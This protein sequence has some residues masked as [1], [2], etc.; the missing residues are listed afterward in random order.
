MFSAPRFCRPKPSSGA[1]S[2]PPL[3]SYSRPM[4]SSRP[5]PVDQP[6][7]PPGGEGL[8]N[9]LRR[10]PGRARTCRPR[11]ARPRQSGDRILDDDPAE[12]RGQRREL[13]G[14][15]IGDLIGFQLARRGQPRDD[16]SGLRPSAVHALTIHAQSGFHA[17][18]DYASRLAVGISP[19]SRLDNRVMPLGRGVA[20]QLIFCA[21]ELTVAKDA[22][23]APTS[24]C[25]LL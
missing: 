9:V 13:R 17:W 14:Q 22:V 7:E 5:L 25:A 18:P 15:R 1:S 24:S 11:M 4:A 12:R 6:E 10:L 16:W 20:D 2:F 19:C 23:A 8:G 21:P 3:G